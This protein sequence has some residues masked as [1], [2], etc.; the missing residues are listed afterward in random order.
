MMILNS[1]SI[2]FINFSNCII[3]T[4]DKKEIK[5]S[6]LWK[7]QTIVFIF[8]RHFSCISCRAHADQVWKN[9]EIYEKNGAKVVFVGNGQVEH[10]KIFKED[11]KIESAIVCTDPELHTFKIIGF[12]RGIVSTIGPKALLNRLELSKAGYQQIAKHKDDGDRW[13]LGGVLV[14]NSLGKILFKYLSEVFGDHPEA[15]LVKTE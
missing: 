6:T 4:E 13:Q 1:N 10:I 2:D 8:L 3:L 9:K 14:V 7:N 15:E 5:I 11:L 12:K